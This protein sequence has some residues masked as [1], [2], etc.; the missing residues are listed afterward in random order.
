MAKISKEKVEKFKKGE[1]KFGQIFDIDAKEVASI[2]LTGHTLYNEGRLED[3]Q[4]VFEG[5]SVLD[6]RNPYVHGI[7]GAIYQKQGKNDVAI[8]RYTLALNIYPQDVN[9]LTNRGEIYLKL[10]KFKE[11]AADFKKAIDLDPNRKN[12]SANRARMLVMLTGN[13][14]SRVAIF[15][16]TQFAS[17]PESRSLRRIRLALRPY[18]N[19]SVP[20]AL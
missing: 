14:G 15:L 10:G 9:S 8:A 18:R 2:M 3:A 7:L 20:A 17:A 12:P 13:V 6:G 4:K 5:L 11:A 1:I 19:R 16:R